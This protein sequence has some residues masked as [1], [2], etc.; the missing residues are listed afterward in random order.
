M[1]ECI[2]VTGGNRGIGRATCEGLAKEGHR[3]LLASR[4]LKEG[5]RVAREIGRDVHAVYL[6]FADTESIEAQVR[7][8]IER[9]PVISALVNNAA[10]LFE[11][12]LIEVSRQD[13]YRSMN[14]NLHGPF[15]L[16][17]VL[18][19]RMITSGYGRIVNVSSSWGAFSQGMDGP[20]AYAI[21]KAALN[22]LTLSLAR[23]MPDTIKV[24]AVDPGWV[25][26]R[27]GGNEANR[28]PENAAETIIWLA[29]IDNNGPSGTF[30]R[31]RKPIAW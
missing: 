13:F 29:T 10:E 21:S 11:G 4:D 25:R 30:F 28:S 16:C 14:S 20:S 24:N 6:D 27:M 12:N 26:T 15:E 3:V 9:Y 2:L 5:R 8:I 17:R 18:V 19:P 1:S 7:A 31:D 22:A 23:S